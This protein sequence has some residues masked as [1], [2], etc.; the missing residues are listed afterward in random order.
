[1]MGIVMRH[2][3]PE[4][5]IGQNNIIYVATS[6]IVQHILI[7]KEKQRHINFFT[8][9]ELLL[10]EAEAFHFSEVR[11]NLQQESEQRSLH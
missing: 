5:S 1:M 3:V 6:R 10:L 4:E 11:G 8:G 7:N 2:D 9:K